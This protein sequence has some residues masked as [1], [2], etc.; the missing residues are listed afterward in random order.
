MIVFWVIDR[1][2][3]YWTAVLNVDIVIVQ[4]ID[5]NYD[6]LVVLMSIRVVCV[7]FDLC[8]KLILLNIHF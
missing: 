2:Y 3:N 5:R 8:L 1:D 7:V 6:M 4:V